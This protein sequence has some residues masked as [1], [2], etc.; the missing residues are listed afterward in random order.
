MRDRAR[1]PTPKIVSATPRNE[2]ALRLVDARVEVTEEADRI[3]PSA[4]PIGAQ[5][6]CADTPA[7]DRSERRGHAQAPS[8]RQQVQSDERHRELGLEQ[9]QP[10]QYPGHRIV[11]RVNGAP[12]TGQQQ[13]RERVVF[14]PPVIARYIG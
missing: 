6:D 5:Q 9:Q 12:R 13:Q 3:E 8:S 4:Q 2:T 10:E 11:I 14:C 1:S 7:P